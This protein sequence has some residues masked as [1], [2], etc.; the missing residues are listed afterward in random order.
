MFLDNDDMYHPMRVGFFKRFATREHSN[1][2]FDAF[3]CDVKLLLDSTQIGTDT[4]VKVETI[5]NMDERLDGKVQV[6]ATPQENSGLDVLE[7]FDFCVRTSV[8]SKFFELTP[9]ELVRNKFCD[10]RFMATLNRLCTTACRDGSGQEWLLMHYR[11]KRYDRVQAFKDKD[12]ERYSNAMLGVEVSEMD[13]K[14]ALDTS[15][16]GRQIAWFAMILKLGQFNILDEQNLLSAR[17]MV[18]SR[19]DRDFGHNIGS[20]L[21]EQTCEDF[22]SYFSDEM[23]EQNK[24][25][26]MEGNAPYGVLDSNAD[27]DLDLCY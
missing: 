15:L 25:W 20:A 19:M 2:D 5:L 18:A 24:N 7:Y 11:V 8:L 6:A 10:V 1:V 13:H 16:D 4:V 14:L 17:E 26:C 12:E 3:W 23:I 27:K 22:S 21:W 9:L